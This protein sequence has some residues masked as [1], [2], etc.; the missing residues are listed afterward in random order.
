[1]TADRAKA[2]DI[3]HLYFIKDLHI[4]HQRLV[5]EVNRVLSWEEEI[6]TKKRDYQFSWS[7]RVIR[8]ES[9]KIGELQKGYLIIFKLNFS[10]TPFTVVC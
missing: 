6:I 10:L 9:I 3:I 4:L 7:P 1:M 5:F 8:D 2:D